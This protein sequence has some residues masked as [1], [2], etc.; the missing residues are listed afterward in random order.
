MARADDIKK[1]NEL[2]AE[3]EKKYKSLKRNSPFKGQ[4]ARDV[5]KSY[6]SIAA[7]T[8]EIET[9]IKGIRADILET[10][11]GLE[12]LKSIFADIGKELG[13]I[14]NPLK[15]M[16][17]GFKKIRNFAEELSDIQYDLTASSAKRYQKFKS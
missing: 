1:L 4:E 8:K 17:S 6:G 5:A 12:G 7:A 10:E 2:L 16:A 13:Q 3:L 9:Q 11:S 14:D 15:K